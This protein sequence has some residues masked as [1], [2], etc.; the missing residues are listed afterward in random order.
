MK[1]AENYVKRQM[2]LVDT[3][4]W[5][6]HNPPV[7]GVNVFDPATGR[8]CE[9]WVSDCAKER[10]LT[11]QYL[12]EVAELSNLQRACGKVVSNG[13]CAG[14]DGMK[15]AELREWFNRNWRSLREDLLTSRYR[16]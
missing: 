10:V 3:E 8:V 6:M 7:C 16:P 14:V 5:R 1:I 12:Q 15:T 4:E 11:S 2:D 13:G 9:Q